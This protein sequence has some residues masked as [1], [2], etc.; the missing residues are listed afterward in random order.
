LRFCAVRSIDGSYKKE[1]PVHPT[2]Q[3]APS[4]ICADQ[5]APLLPVAVTKPKA[6]LRPQQ[7][8]P[9]RT[10]IPPRLQAEA[11]LIPYG[12]LRSAYGGST[13]TVPAIMVGV[14]FKNISTQGS[15]GACVLC[16]VFSYIWVKL[17]D[18]EREKAGIGSVSSKKAVG[19]T[20]ITYKNEEQ[21]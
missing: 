2:T 18:K 17:D 11:H 10:G 6:C 13:T 4:Q 19:T 8:P 21:Q 1:A 3:K 7:F 5:H 9:S 12:H 20:K 16:G 14:M 15:I